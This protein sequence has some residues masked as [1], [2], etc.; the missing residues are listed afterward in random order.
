MEGYDVWG[1]GFCVGQGW[2]YAGQIT[3]GTPGHRAA[4]P[5]ALA[6]QLLHPPNPLCLQLVQTLLAGEPHAIHALGVGHTQAS[7][8]P[9]SQQ[10]HGH[11][12]QC[13]LAETWGHGVP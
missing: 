4:G 11:L 8:L 10:Q 2:G 12:V 9:A 1:S 3:Q 6:R 7:A 13:D 5:P